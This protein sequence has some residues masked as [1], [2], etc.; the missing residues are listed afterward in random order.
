MQLV[1]IQFKSITF[2]T[3]LPGIWIYSIKPIS[4]LVSLFWIQKT[5]DKYRKFK[6]IYII[7]LHD[8][9]SN[10]I[11]VGHAFNFKK[12]PSDHVQNKV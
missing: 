7:I 10:R 3:S 6:H 2:F 8:T 9:F 1:Y 12:K 4:K 5:N 11:G